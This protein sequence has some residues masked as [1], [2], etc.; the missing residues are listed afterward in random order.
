KAM[1]QFKAVILY[2][3]IN[4]TADVEGQKGKPN[5]RAGL[6]KEARGDYVRSYA[7][8]ATGT[9]NEGKARFGSLAKNPDDLRT[10]MKQLATLYYEDGK[11]KEAAL[12]F[13]MLITERPSAPDAPGFQSKIIDCVLRAGN[14]QMTVQQVRRL[15]KIVGDVKAANPNPQGKD[16][17]SITEA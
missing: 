6:V 3:E 10:M 1:D 14:K 13:N 16:K 11:D 7:R 15:V 12:A 5:S 9:P 8:L 4:G 2:S 17:D